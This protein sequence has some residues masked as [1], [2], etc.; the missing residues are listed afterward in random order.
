VEEI[1]DRLEKEKRVNDLANIERSKRMSA[2]YNVFQ[3]EPPMPDDAN[4]IYAPYI[5]RKFFNIEELRLKINAFPFT[6]ISKD[7]VYDFEARFQEGDEIWHYSNFGKIC[8]G[9]QIECLLLIRNNKVIYSPLTLMSYF[10]IW[11]YKPPRCSEALLLPENYVD[12]NGKHPE[13]WTS[14]Y[15]RD[16][17]FDKKDLQEGKWLLALTDKESVD[18]IKLIREHRGIIEIPPCE[19]CKIDK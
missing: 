13:I 16:V 17:V 15:A 10:E 5:L 11:S 12:I 14:F 19:K 3:F 6:H 8:T 7:L 2:F 4:S 9:D 1:K 18:L